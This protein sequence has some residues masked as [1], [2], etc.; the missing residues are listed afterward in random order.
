MLHVACLLY[1]DGNEFN[2]GS[3]SIPV[4]QVRH[5]GAMLLVVSRPPSSNLAFVGI[6]SLVLRLSSHA[7][8]NL[9]GFVGLSNVIVII[10]ILQCTNTGNYAS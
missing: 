9:M 6:S 7:V 1:T 2:A 8:A 4:A 3:V 5:N 10:M